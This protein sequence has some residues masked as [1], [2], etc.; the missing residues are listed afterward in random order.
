MEGA[1]EQC[2]EGTWRDTGKPLKE[3][4]EAWKE[5]SGAGEW[6][7]REA[8]RKGAAVSRL[9]GAWTRASWQQPVQG[10]QPLLG[11]WH[12]I[13]TGREGREGHPRGGGGSARPLCLAS[14]TP[15][16]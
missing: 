1:L 4:G 12:C 14:V 5:E 15:V 11:S 13:A 9:V 3:K 2:L 10:C 7:G 8:G 16:H 6:E